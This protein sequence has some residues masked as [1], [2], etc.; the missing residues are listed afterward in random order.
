MQRRVLVQLDLRHGAGRAVIGGVLRFAA[1]HPE[2][3]L[4][5]LGGHPSNEPICDY[6]SWRPLGIITDQPL[7]NLRI[8]AFCR[9]GLKALVTFRHENHP[10]VQLGIVHAGCN[11]RLIAEAAARLL[12]RKG[13]VHFAY[14]PAPV[15]DMELHEREK[16]FCRL[17]SEK[18]FKPDVYRPPQRFARWTDEAQTLSA[19]LK[20][21]PKPCGIMAAF[22]QRAKH[23]IDVCRLSGILV[24]EQIQIVGVDNETFICEQTIPSLTSVMPDFEGLGFLTANRIDH[25]IRSPRKGV[26]QLQGSVMGVVE[27]LSTADHRGAARCVSLAQEFIRLHAAAG[28]TVSDVVK[29]SRTSERLLQRHFK[30]ICGKSVRDEL[31]DARLELVKERL[32]TTQIPIDRIGDFCGFPNVKNL[33]V[34]F[35]Q[36]FGMTMGNYRLRHADASSPAL[37]PRLDKIASPHPTRLIRHDLRQFPGD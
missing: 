11:Q 14:V 13:L 26:F 31:I 32:R 5:I 22:D 34:R 20:A 28:I 17:L 37:K 7:A 24:P 2:W 8:P 36:H 19:W 21:L 12:I 25:L 33:K 4:Q 23:V 16:T 10:D 30:K 35:R 3:D 6:L 15:D 27:R 1:L 18:G 9:N 29:A